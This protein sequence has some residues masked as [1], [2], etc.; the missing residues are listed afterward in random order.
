MCTSAEEVKVNWEAIKKQEKQAKDRHL[1][2]NVVTSEPQKANIQ[3]DIPNSLP[4]VQRVQKIQDRVSK[5][6]FE[7]R[8]INDAIDKLQEEVA[9]I[10][11]AVEQQDLANMEEELGDCFFALL[12]VARLLAMDPELA[13]KKANDKFV[14]RFE[15]VLAQC[16]QA[17]QDMQKTEIEV[18]MTY[19]KLAK[20]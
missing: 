19:W 7:W 6:G 3:A 11:Q 10:R 5:M 8:S 2:N 17:G 16:E 18:L 15:A 12:K 20:G 1:L 14:K 13:L 9:E 4:I